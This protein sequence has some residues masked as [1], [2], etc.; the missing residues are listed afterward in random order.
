MTSADQ[1]PSLIPLRRKSILHYLARHQPVS[2]NQLAQVLEQRPSTLTYAI[3]ELLEAGLVEETEPVR[4]A[5]VGRPAIGLRLRAGAMRFLGIEFDQ[6]WMHGAIVGFDGAPLHTRSHPAGDNRN[7]EDYCRQLTGLARDLLEEAGPER[8]AGIG[9]GAPG[10]VD[11]KRGIGLRYDLIK[12]WHQVPLAQILQ[13]THALPVFIDNNASCFALA[14]ACYGD[15]AGLGR[16]A[17]VLVRTGV[18]FG[19]AEE[20]RMR[21]SSTVSGGELGHMTANPRGARCRCGRRGCLETQISGWV[22]QRRLQRLWKQH[23]EL[24]QQARALSGG[25]EIGI[26]HLARLAQ[27]GAL[28]LAELFAEMFDAL[29]T[30]LNNLI[31]LVVPDVVVI[32]GRFNGAAALMAPRLAEVVQP[33]SGLPE[34]APRI[35]IP[36]GEEAMGAVGAALMALHN[37]LRP[38]LLEPGR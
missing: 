32:H 1:T 11:L 14:S 38:P 19:M 22:L 12:D 26:P 9:L 30:A 27:Q 8:V 4:E 7:R 10:V 33:R 37:T 5:G 20:R 18:G 29:G 31:N 24:A 6:E 35:V 36:Q 2:R 21:L 17:A 28:P 23:P 16:V 25:D 34:S 15:A 3:G 13:A